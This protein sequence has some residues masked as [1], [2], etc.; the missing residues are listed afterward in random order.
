MNQAGAGSVKKR[1]FPG[2]TGKVDNYASLPI[3]LL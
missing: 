3:I 1:D 2:K